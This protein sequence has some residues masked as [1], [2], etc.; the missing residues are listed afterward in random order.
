MDDEKKYVSRRLGESK[1]LICY[2][3]VKYRE[4]SLTLSV[5]VLDGDWCALHKDMKLND[6]LAEIKSRFI[7][8]SDEEYLIREIVVGG[9]SPVDIN[10]VIFGFEEYVWAYNIKTRVYEQL[11][12]PSFLRN[13]LP[14]IEYIRICFKAKANYTSTSFLE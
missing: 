5:W 7:D 8:G 4:R 3:T 10:V 1:G 13:N 6:W 9:F 2:T 12:H 11:C 14:S